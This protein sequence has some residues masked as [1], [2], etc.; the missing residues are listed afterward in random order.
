MINHYGALQRTGLLS[1]FETHFVGLSLAAG[2]GDQIKE[3]TIILSD[4]AV[5]AVCTQALWTGLWRPFRRQWSRCRWRHV[6]LF[7]AARDARG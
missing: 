5:S 3:A 6:G 4:R 2:V 1:A 7:S